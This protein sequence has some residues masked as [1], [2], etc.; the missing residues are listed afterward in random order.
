MDVKKTGSAE[1]TVEEVDFT[2]EQTK[3]QMLANEQSFIQ[4]LLEAVDYKEQETQL[5]EIVRGGKVFF[6]F[7][8]RPLGE[9]EYNQ[10]RKRYTK[11]VRNKQLGVKLPEDTDNVKYRCSL[12]FN[13]TV[14]EDQ[15]ALWNN[16][17]I[18][19]ALEGKGRPIVNALDVIEAALLG[20][21]K[22]QI[23]DAIDRLSGFNNNNLEEV[24]RGREEAVKN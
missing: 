22:D 2:K 6:A 15:A 4:G 20:G 12:I 24:E 14:E 23:I 13:A 9:D 11:Y 16:K 17:E 10:C 19:K 8:I 3:N 5:I 18:W 7:R 1:T 21:E